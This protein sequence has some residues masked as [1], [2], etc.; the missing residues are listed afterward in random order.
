MNKTHSVMVQPPGIYLCIRKMMDLIQLLVSLSGHDTVYY[1][2]IILL[3]VKRNSICIYRVNVVVFVV[4][5]CNFIG[6]F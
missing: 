4:Q 2:Y 1:M 6:L 5:F 3:N